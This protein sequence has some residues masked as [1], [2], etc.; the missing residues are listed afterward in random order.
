MSNLKGHLFL[1][2][3]ANMK[4][5]ENCICM[6]ECWYI[7]RLSKRF[8]L[9]LLNLKYNLYSFCVNIYV[10]FFV[11]FFF[12]FEH[13]SNKFAKITGLQII[14]IFKVI[15]LYVVWRKLTVHMWR[16]VWFRQHTNI[17]LVYVRENVNW[18]QFY[19]TSSLLPEDRWAQCC[20]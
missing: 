13:T 14:M 4:I 6:C 15:F 2:R 3:H 20:Q 5:F 7:F 16:R 1:F 8:I 11:L 10:V 19:I 17:A 9:P 18:E 12:A